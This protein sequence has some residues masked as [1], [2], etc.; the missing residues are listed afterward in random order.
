MQAE[1]LEQVGDPYA[2]PVELQEMGLD[3]SADEPGEGG[4]EMMGVAVPRHL[5]QVVLPVL[6]KLVDR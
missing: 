5:P 4:L 3:R 2:Q 6:S 1:L